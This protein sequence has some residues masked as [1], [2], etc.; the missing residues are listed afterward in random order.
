MLQKNPQHSKSAA[1]S[2]SYMEKHGVQILGQMKPEYS[3]V[4]TPEAIAFVGHIQRKFG[5][6]VSDLMQKRQERQAKYATYHDCV[7]G[8]DIMPSG[9]SYN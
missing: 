4:L 8:S 2:H 9:P 7:L 6:R 3:Q 1:G 5:S